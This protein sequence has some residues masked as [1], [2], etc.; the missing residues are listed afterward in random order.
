MATKTL[1]QARKNKADEFYTQLVDIEQELRHYKEQ[2]RGKTVFCNCDDPYESN[3]FKFF[4]MSFNSWELKKLIATCYIGSPIASTQLTLFDNEPAENKTTKSPH[5]IVITEVDDYNADGATDLADVEY[6]LRNKKNT[7]TRLEGNG[8]FRS[9]E[10]IELLKE[11]DIVVTN[12]PFSLFKEYIAQL[13]EHGKNF[14]VLGN[15][16]ALA[17]K[18]TFA[19]I[20]ENKLAT[21][22]RNIN[23]DMWFIVPD[24]Y[25]YEKIEN[26]HKVKHIMACWF[27]NLNVSKH[28]EI[29][30]LYKRYNPKV[31]PRYDNYDAI[32]VDKVM[33]I[34]YDYGGAIGVP[35]TFL[36]K[37]NPDQFKI[38]GLSASAGYNAEIV[39]LPK[40]PKYKDARP[41]I[42]G[43]NTYARVFIRHKLIYDESGNKI[44]ER[45]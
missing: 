5:K 23:N 6:L 10:C 31:Y 8:D 13:M 24:G 18:E 30:S 32:N 3:F 14:L 12:P 11:S 36:D 9:A 19:Y 39:G 16:N 35:I 44:G 17:Y 34:P 15:K 43:K 7:L 22:Y 40:D 25:K 27:T 45:K 42:N 1:D 2:F 37:H 26:G 21:G 28:N 20:A 4:A 33:D 38:I 41:L 29:M